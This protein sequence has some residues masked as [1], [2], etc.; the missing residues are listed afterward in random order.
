MMMVKI[1]LRHR[2]FYSSKGVK[3]VSIHPL[4]FGVL[5]SAQADLSWYRAMQVVKQLDTWRI[6]I[7]AH[8]LTNRLSHI[9]LNRVLFQCPPH[10]SP[11]YFLAHL[12]LWFLTFPSFHHQ[13][14][15]YAYGMDFSQIVHF[16]HHHIW[17]INRFHQISIFPILMYQFVLALQFS[18]RKLQNILEFP[19]LFKFTIHAQFWDYTNDLQ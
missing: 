11:F 13:I 1:W 12:A 4:S 3:F 15:H 19:N 9:T 2:C 5:Q 8:I 7:C 16:V 6:I 10:S 14:R 18:I 17:I